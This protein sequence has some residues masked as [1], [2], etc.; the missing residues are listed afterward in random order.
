MFNL[1]RRVICKNY[2]L[3]FIALFVGMPV[4]A[5]AANEEQIQYCLNESSGIHLTDE[6]MIVVTRTPLAITGDRKALDRAFMKAELRAKGIMIR[7]MAENHSSSLN[8]T[9]SSEDSTG[10]KQLIDVNGILTS[11]EVSSKQKDVLTIIENNVSTGSLVGVRKF[12]ELYSPEKGEVCVA[13]GVSAESINQSNKF[14]NMMSNPDQV[15]MKKNKANTEITLKS[16]YR[17]S[18]W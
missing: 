11:T 2:N 6:K 14:K 7:D 15:R 3:F 18:A 16:F 8:S 4:G 9:D 17:R 12:E 5:N 10:S 13:I 1:Y